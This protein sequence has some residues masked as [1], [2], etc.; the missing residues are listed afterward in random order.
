MVANYYRFSTNSEQDALTQIDWFLVNCVGWY[1][2][3]TISDTSSDRDYVY[4]SDG[5]RDQHGNPY[6]RIIR[7][8]A[9]GNNIYH[10]SYDTYTDS[11][12]YTHEIY[13]SSATNG[14][15]IYNI[16]GNLVVTVIADKERVM[17]AVERDNAGTWFVPTYVGRLTPLYGPDVDPY[18]NAVKGTTRSHHEWHENDNPF[19]A[20]TKQG[21]ALRT[22]SSTTSFTKNLADCGGPC[23]RNNKFF[24]ASLLLYETVTGDSELRGFPRGAYCVNEKLAHRNLLTLASGT[25]IVLKS[26][27]PSGAWA[28][29]PLIDSRNGDI[30]GVPD[31]TPQIDFNY[32]GFTTP[33]SA[34]ANWRLDELVSG[35]YPD[36]TGNYN[37]SPSGS[38]VLVDSPLG[39]G[40]SFNGSSQYLSASGDAGSAAALNGEWTAEIVFN[41]ADVS[42]TQTL[43]CYQGPGETESENN[44]LTI[45]ISGSDVVVA[46]E[47]GAGTDVSNATTSDFLVVDRWNYLAVVKKENGSFYDISI[48]H[49]SFGDHEPYLVETFSSVAGSTGGDASSWAVASDS[50]GSN[51]FEGVIDGVRVTSSALTFEEVRDSAFRVRL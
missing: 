38:P 24:A 14:T 41:P 2:I 47:T 37:L 20:Y 11:T 9:N 33:A 4:T 25:H 27:F 43:L 31:P 29:G 23:S 39:N 16:P 17:V 51:Y 32:R 46:W 22:F 48:W 42:T 34:V 10:Y 19:W 13:S 28:Y 36:Q 40:L 45:S 35:E 6:P 18:P 1:R 26:R 7:L 3:D 8:R 5:E 15:L 50:S 30:F 44:L 12:T 49:Q 21:D